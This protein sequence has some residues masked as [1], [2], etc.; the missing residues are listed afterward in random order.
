MKI[1]TTTT[2][3]TYKFHANR[4]VGANLRHAADPLDHTKLRARALHPGDAFAERQ[5]GRDW[6]GEERIVR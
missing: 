1:P 2:T 3:K 6:L 5:C 4:P